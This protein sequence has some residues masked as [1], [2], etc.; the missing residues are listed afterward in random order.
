MWEALLDF[1]YGRDDCTVHNYWDTRAPLAVSDP[2]CK[3]LLLQR[4]DGLL[5]VLATWN[6][7]PAAVTVGLDGKA[8]GGRYTKASDAE[9]AE[10]CAVAGNRVEVALPGYG[11]RVLSLYR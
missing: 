1:G 3:W 7:K 6:P 10:S 2:E 5:L 8:L 9:S 11:V 4:G